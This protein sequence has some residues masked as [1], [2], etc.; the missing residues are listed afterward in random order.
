MPKHDGFWFLE[1]ARQLADKELANTPII[2]LTNL[3]DPETRRHC[4]E[5][6][7]LYYLVK[8][9]HT[10]SELAKLVQDIMAAKNSKPQVKIEE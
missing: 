2:M 8:P 1:K 5:L 4:A 10:P 7:C 3:D 9:L 6:Q